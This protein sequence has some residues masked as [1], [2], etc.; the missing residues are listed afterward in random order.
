VG[1]TEE[2]VGLYD[3]RAGVIRLVWAAGDPVSVPDGSE[4]VRLRF[5][6][7]KQTGKSAYELLTVIQ[8]ND[9]TPA[10]YDSEYG[11]VVLQSIRSNDNSHLVERSDMTPELQVLSSSPNPFTDYTA[12]RFM[13]PETGIITTSLYSADG[14]LLWSHSRPQLAGYGEVEITNGDL[15]QPGVYFLELRGVFG[16][17][18]VRL[19]RN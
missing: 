8:E 12:V 19:V 16:R 18:T 3:V 2:G 5:R 10:A 7:L 1:L 14:R 11:E 13:M 4:L 6:A 9:L 15:L 17:K